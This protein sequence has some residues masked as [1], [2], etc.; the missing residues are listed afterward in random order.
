MKLWNRI[1]SQ[2]RKHNM[3]HASKTAPDGLIDLQISF[4]L[5]HE[6]H[7]TIS[8]QQQEGRTLPALRKLD[9]EGN[10][11][12]TAGGNRPWGP[13]V[14]ILR[15]VLPRDP[16]V[17]VLRKYSDSLEDV[18]RMMREEI[19]LQLFALYQAA[20]IRKNEA[21]SF[22]KVVRRNARLLAFCQK[23]HSVEE[24]NQALGDAI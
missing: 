3:N 4:K 1:V 13:T 17:Q 24:I 5:I 9:H 8:F 23:H 18:S 20:T 15:L 12:M 19:P 11:D 22:E 10:P 2:V 14:H 6:T 7:D 16:D 21:E